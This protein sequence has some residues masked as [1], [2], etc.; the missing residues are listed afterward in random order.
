MAFNF[1]RK[2][3][4]AVPALLG[5]AFIAKTQTSELKGPAHFPAMKGFS[6]IA[7]ESNTAK[8]ESQKGYPNVPGETIDAVITDYIYKF[9]H[10]KGLAAPTP[11]Q[12]SEYYADL[13]KKA[14]GRKSMEFNGSANKEFFA[15]GYVHA[16]KEIWIN[17]SKFVYNRD[18]SVA[19]YTI[20]YIE[21]AEAGYINAA[22]MDKAIKKEGKVALDI[23]FKTG[24]ST[25]ME[26]SLSQVYE[27]VT[28][29]RNDPALKVSIEGHTDKMGSAAQ[30]KD[31]SEARAKA[32][33]DI[34]QRK[35]IDAGRLRTIGWGWSKPVSDNKTEMGRAQNRRV[36]I[37]KQ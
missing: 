24:E 19:G 17:V 22:A 32:V 31:L 23:H 35:G 37:V 26:E 9:A 36:E 1:L 10:K 5:L 12:V 4:T 14:P 28:M 15:G 27:L 29:L 30:N 11:K 6:L 18:S 33:K 25:V 7:A 13:M 20:H 21:N 2:A 3:Q 34:L 8:A 16:G